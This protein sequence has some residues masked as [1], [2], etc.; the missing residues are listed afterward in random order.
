MNKII[1]LLL[2]CSLTAFLA[3]C[4][5]N[6]ERHELT[7]VEQPFVLYAD[8]TVDSLSFF[9]FDSWSVVSQDEWI[10]VDGDSHLD[11][12]Y[13]NTRRYLFRVYLKLQPNTTGETRAGTVLVK[14]YDY[15]FSA[16][17]VQ[18]GILNLSHPA[19]T[20]D[21][22]FDEY[23][24]IPRTAHYELVDSAHW[25]EDSICFTVQ[26]SWNLLFPDEKPDWISL[27]RTAASAGQYSVKL[28][29]EPNTDTDN[30]R[31]AKLKLHSG[32]VSNEI[33]VRQL[34]AKKEAKE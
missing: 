23:G 7:P 11:F 34:P 9:T 2:A 22:P 26:N 31:Q 33:V 1:T 4:A 28:T 21:T 32:N 29:L 15:A 16:P 17:F 30:G 12:D 25:T 19:Y 5:D 13:D 14:S 10:A 27:D 3:S 18:L 24:I 6:S 20:A 8:Q